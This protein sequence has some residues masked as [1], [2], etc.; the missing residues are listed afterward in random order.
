M[1]KQ[2]DFLRFGQLTVW[3]PILLFPF[4][5]ILLVYQYQLSAE[6]SRTGTDASDRRLQFDGYLKAK[7]VTRTTKVSDYEDGSSARTFNDNDFYGVL[8][9]DIT[10][11][12]KDSFE[13]HL[14]A[15]GKND[16]DGNQDDQG[17]NPLEG[18]EDTQPES[19]GR[20]YRAHLDAN[21]FLGFEQIRLGRQSDTRGEWIYFDGISGDMSVGSMT[22]FTLYLGQPVHH[23]EKEAGS[24]SIAGLGIDLRFK[25]GTRLQ[26]DYLSSSDERT[27]RIDFYDEENKRIEFEDQ[28]DQ[29]LTFRWNQ[30]YGDSAKSRMKM[31]WLN[32]EQRDVELRAALLEMLF[33]FDLYANYYRQLMTEAQL[34]NE[35]SAYFD[36]LGIRKPFQSYEI[37]VSRRFMT[38]YIVDLGT[39]QR[40]L[41]EEEDESSFNREFTRTYII[42]EV[43]RFIAEGATV[44][45]S[46]EQWE[47]DTY[48]GTASG[49]DAAY[50]LSSD[51]QSMVFNMG[52]YFSLYKYDYYT[53]LGERTNVQTFYAEAEVPFLRQYTFSVLYEYEFSSEYDTGTKELA[54]K[55]VFTVRRDF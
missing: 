8:L 52:S 50:R 33:G 54:E 45:I 49:F 4:L 35:M 22:S 1:L 24:D 40:S 36:V 15:S 23:H 21:E 7:Y 37:K 18:L 5:L 10:D 6:E 31:R 20:V 55:G 3:K 27:N 25:T 9:L 43:E 41:L 29:Q 2:Y 38:D 28:E 16:L 51:P 17:Y 42:F 46:Q 14:F 44:S 39:Y 32:G 11:S 34:S 19:Y 47:S 30:F 12:K 48:S 13:F 53:E 26:F